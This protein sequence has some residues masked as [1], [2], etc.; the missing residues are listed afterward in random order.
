[1]LPP[2]LLVVP[3]PPLVSLVSLVSLA[4]AILYR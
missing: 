3:P 1:M 2:N 4:D